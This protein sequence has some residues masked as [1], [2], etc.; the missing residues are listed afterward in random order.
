MK[1]EN[2]DRGGTTLNPDGGCLRFIAFVFDGHGDYGSAIAEYAVEEFPE[3]LHKHIN[4]CKNNP[5]IYQNQGLNY[6]NSNRM[7]KDT[8]YDSINT[9]TPVKKTCSIQKVFPYD[10]SSLTSSSPKRKSSN[11]SKSKSLL[12]RE[13]SKSKY[14]NL[15]NVVHQSAG[16]YVMKELLK[17]HSNNINT[18]L[19]PEILR[20]TFIELHKNMVEASSERC[21]VQLSGCTATAIFIEV[22]NYI[23]RMIY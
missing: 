20:N 18:S 12:F 6:I 13:R 17:D 16:K 7:N 23:F 8:S 9:N 19:I 14:L 11:K 5:E 15:D 22:L 21:N 10:S 1:R 3:V 4:L 2:Q